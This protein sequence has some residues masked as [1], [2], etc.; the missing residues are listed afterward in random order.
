MYIYTYCV[1]QAP[2]PSALPGPSPPPDVK[3]A[4]GQKHK[5]GSYG[6]WSLEAGSGAGMFFH[7]GWCTEEEIVRVCRG[8]PLMHHQHSASVSVSRHSTDAS[9]THI[10]TAHLEA[11]NP[12]QLFEAY[13]EFHTRALARTRQTGHPLPPVLLCQPMYGL[14]NRMRAMMGCLMIAMVSKR[15]MFVDWYHNYTF[16][17]ADEHRDMPGG[18]V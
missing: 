11:D 2:T 1:L 12:E 13:A 8:I 15:V 17:M 7:T 4:G 14:G 3:Q 5:M 9:S 10:N 6:G 18:Q 16:F